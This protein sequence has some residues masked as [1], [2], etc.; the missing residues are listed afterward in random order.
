MLSGWALN[1]LPLAIKLVGPRRWIPGL[2]HAARRRLAGRRPREKFDHCLSSIGVRHA[3][4]VPA[5]GLWRQPVVTGRGGSV[6][7]AIGD[8]PVMSGIERL[9]ELAVVFAANVQ[10]GQMVGVT[11]EVGHLEM[12]RAV[13][14]AA[15]RAGAR[16][17][18]VHLRDPH[19]ERS[20]VV[21]AAAETVGYSPRWAEARIRELDE[22]RGANIKITGPTA[23][24]LFDDLDPARVG[25]AQGPRSRAWREVEYRVN[26]TIIPGPTLAWA[27]SLRPSSTPAG[28]LSA[29]MDDLRVACR[30]D[31][32]DPVVA[33]RERFAE[34][35]IRARALTALR[36]HAVR[37]H[38]PG[39]DLVIGL[40]PTR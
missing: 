3:T 30:L 11:A 1:R 21:H 34:L 37:F 6:G 33:W 15:Y 38:G 17:V 26:N 14:D 35:G 2:V 29:L 40:P 12:V 7:D 31:Q 13:A 19:L 25:Q 28:A 16:Y 32:P 10:P 23:P 24:G 20:W 27:E 4:D 36:L 39:T 22:E 8:D 18:D 9:A 5:S